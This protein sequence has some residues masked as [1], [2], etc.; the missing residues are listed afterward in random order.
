MDFEIIRLYTLSAKLQSKYLNASK[1]LLSP[2]Y[3]KG[4]NNNKCLDMPL[5]GN[6]LDIFIILW[7]NAESPLPLLIPIFSTYTWMKFGNSLTICS[8]V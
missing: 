6:A 5:I 1:K 7:D 3:T 4:F 8:Q 2:Y